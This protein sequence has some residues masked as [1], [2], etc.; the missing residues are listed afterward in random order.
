MT[1]KKIGFYAVFALV[2][3]VGV[4]LFSSPAH[5]TESQ[6]EFVA[7]ELPGDWDTPPTAA[8][9]FDQ[10]A[11]LFH[12][13]TTDLS[14]VTNPTCS[15]W[16]Q[17]DEYTTPHPFGPGSTLTAYGTPSGDQDYVQA[18]GFV[19][20][21][22]CPKVVTPEPEPEPAAELAETGVTETTLWALGIMSAVLVLFGTALLTGRRTA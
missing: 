6:N 8:T 7:W 5:A 11:Q 16:Y 14:I 13:V 20:G 21:G 17:V 18:W 12:G 15:K 9:A 3:T 19:Y 4:M 22:D 10:G 1:W 2:V